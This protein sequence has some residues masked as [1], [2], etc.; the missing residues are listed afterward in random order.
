MR[1]ENRAL[2]AFYQSSKG[3]VARHLISRRLRF[4]WP[5]LK[6]RCLLGLGYAL[7]YLRPFMAET[8]RTLATMP[9]EQGA[10]GW[11]P[12]GRNIAALVEEAALPFPDSSFDCL[13]VIHA[14]EMSE[15]QR[16]FMRELW[17]VLSSDGR[18]IVVVPSRTGLWAQFESSPFGHGRPY[19][20]SQLQYLLEQSLFGIEHWDSA[21]F[22]PPFGRRSPRNGEGWDRLGRRLWPRFAGVHIVET[23]KSLYTPVPF[24]L[25]RAR[26]RW[27]PAGAGS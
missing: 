5:D 27:A 21:L 12:A 10:E 19:S 2:R 14:L 6:G 9:A 26:R 16:S 8:E 4:L 23:T 25:Q 13:L 7:P 20:R 18:L 11:P 1:L 3:Q 15:V 22:M 17:R 24:A